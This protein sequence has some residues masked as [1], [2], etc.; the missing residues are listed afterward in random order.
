MRQFFRLTPDNAEQFAALYNASIGCEDCCYVRAGDDCVLLDWVDST[1]PNAE[2][3]VDGAT[4]PYGLYER[5]KDGQW[6][7]AE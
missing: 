3:F 1:A 6:C 7:L 2:M 5:D 4:F